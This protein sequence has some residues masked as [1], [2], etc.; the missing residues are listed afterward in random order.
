MTLVCIMLF[1]RPSL[2]L[3]RDG[4]PGWHIRTGQFILNTHQIPHQ[5]PFSFSMPD[6]RWV[7]WQ[8]GTEIIFGALD[9]RF[10]LNGVAFFVVLM[11]AGSYTLLYKHLRRE[12]FSFTLSFALLLFVL[13]GS[14]FHWTARPLVMSYLFSVLFVFF[15]DPF[16]QGKIPAQRLWPLPLLMVLWVNM[17]PGFVAGLIL[18]L[19][20]WCSA[21]L[22]YIFSSAGRRPAV[23]SKL[24]HTGVLAAATF[25]ASLVNP[26]GY[27]IY[28]YLFR[29]L[30]MVHDLVFSQNELSSP[31]FQIAVFQPFLLAV[32]SLL[33][34]IRYSHYRLRSEECFLLSAWVALGLV[35]LRNIPIMLLICAPIY[36]RLLEGLKPP[37]GE[38]LAQVP[39][40]RDRLERMF[41]RLERVVAIERHVK[42]PILSSTLLLVFI[43]IVAHHGILGGRP[44]MNFQFS[45]EDYPTAALQ[46]LKSDRPAG[47][48]FNE[49]TLGGYL[50]YNFYPDIRVFVDGRI[51]FYGETFTRNYVELFSTPQGS[52]GH[53]NWKEV[54]ARY[55]IQWVMIPPHFALRYV[56]DA[57]SD[58]QRRFLD[59]T[60]VIFVKRAGQV[61]RP[62]LDTTIHF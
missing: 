36:A 31:H 54:F 43:W 56:L 28:P 19:I 52:R 44:M 61:S 18:V 11:L 50:I 8:W 55:Q 24:K 13:L 27:T 62:V 16:L 42:I 26:Y 29:Y 21:L 14:K 12:G 46:Y 10:G 23:T 2:Y 47:N 37:L 53:G 5:D 3:F 45:G 39:R 49:L 48:V 4:D 1:G 22:E 40:L 25:A 32:V 20:F 58:W 15:L 38:W 59:S 51:D 6:T 41:N 30:R 57:D 33:F 9:R 7:A 34:L 35:S 60:C 17:H